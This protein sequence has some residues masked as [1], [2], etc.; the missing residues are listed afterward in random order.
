[1]SGP[2]ATEEIS[3]MQADSTEC[4]RCAQIVAKAVAASP[5]VYTRTEYGRG[6]TDYVSVYVV[7]VDQRIQNITYYVATAAGL[8][9]TE[10]GIKYGGG[11]YSKG[12]EAFES[13][14][15]VAGVTVDQRRWEELR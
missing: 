2:V 12:L 11:Q 14:C 7:S 1:M 5:M 8:K 9:M 13:A 10:R 15:I 4:E 3:L 6:E